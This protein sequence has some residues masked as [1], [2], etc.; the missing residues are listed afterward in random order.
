MDSKRIKPNDNDSLGAKVFEYSP[1]G[2]VLFDEGGR[3]LSVN[4][5]AGKMFQH[6]PEELC[7][8]DVSCLL[9]E[10]YQQQLKKYI[11]YLLQMGDAEYIGNP[12]EAMGSRGDESE[13]AIEFTL[14][15]LPGEKNHF[16]CTIRDVSERKWL[17]GVLD[18]AFDFCIRLF[19]EFPAMIWRSGTDGKSDYFNR[20]W[21][22]FT[23]RTVEQEKGD[24]WSEGIYSE[25]RER[26]IQT[27]LSAFERREAF[28]MEY[29]LRGHDGQ[30]RW[31]VDI[32][33]PFCDFDGQF[34]GYIGYCFDITE[35]KEAEVVL[36]RYQLLSE[37]AR[38]I[39]LFVNSDG[40]IID[41]NRAAEKVY[42]YDRSEF[43][44]LYIHQL[45]QPGEHELIQRQLEEAMAK[46]CLFETIHRR[47]D[48]SLFPVEVNTVSAIIGEEKMV[49]SVVRDLTERKQADARMVEARE[50]ANRA[51]RMASLGTMAAGIAHEI[52]QP[53]NSLKVT[54]D[55]MLYWHKK[56]KT[57]EV[58]KLIDNIQKISSQAGRINDIIT[59]IRSFVHSEQKEQLVACD[60]NR[61]VEGALSLLGSQLSSHGIE[62]QIVLA[63][64]LPPLQAVANRLEEL[65][66]NLLVNAMHALDVSDRKSKIVRI[67]TRAGATLRD[68]ETKRNTV[69]LDIG[70]NG[71]GIPEELHGRVFEPFFTTKPAGEGMG[72]GLSIAHSIVTSFR[73][74]IQVKTNDENGA[75][76]TVIFPSMEE[77]VVLDR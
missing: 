66:I 40:K 45:R 31:I 20:G 12:I 3:I 68:G 47:K 44:E 46:G 15:V 29:R 50:R 34:A 19:D 36:Q 33:R 4:R 2:I 61:A 6:N 10:P 14:A 56:G 39:L 41:V 69:E 59:H 38:D 11:D 58:S 9:S 37:R 64:Q 21:L 51:E 35:R 43:L 24:G 30:Y 73:G 26:C 42:G 52:N 8:K 57:V 72:L 27:Y 60:L 32:G 53:L 67:S 71:S 75:T 76:F 5:A 28:Q 65:I 17:R 74:H 18:Q 23:G 49:F 48:G 22:Q 62:V 16:I 1:D 77:T 7:G 55:S 63:P 13:I 70:D 25:D 54:A